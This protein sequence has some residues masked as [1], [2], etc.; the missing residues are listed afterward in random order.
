MTPGSALLKFP[1][2]DVLLWYPLMLAYYTL[3]LAVARRR[4]LLAL[5]ALL[6]ALAFVPVFLRRR[7][8]LDRVNFARWREVRNCY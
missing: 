8:P 7:A 4:P 5:R 6:L 1:F 2:P 3:Q